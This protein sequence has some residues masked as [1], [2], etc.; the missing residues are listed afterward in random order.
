MSA[1]PPPID[2]DFANTMSEP[3]TGTHL[4]RYGGM[5]KFGRGG[6]FYTPHDAPTLIDLLLMADWLGVR[7]PSEWADHPEVAK[8]ARQG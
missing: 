1:T 7:Y 2:H 8:A 6:S 5:D 4:V 3:G